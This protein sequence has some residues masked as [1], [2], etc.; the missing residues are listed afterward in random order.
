MDKNFETLRWG[1]LVTRQYINPQITQELHTLGIDSTV[2][3]NTY[4]YNN[5][6][7]ESLYSEEQVKYFSKKFTPYINDYIEE[8]NTYYHRSN[9]P[10]TKN[11]S[12]E[13]L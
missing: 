10:T 7:Q 11:W 2:P 1:P 4:I 8:H 13:T 9:Y 5:L 3:F 12:L 6:D